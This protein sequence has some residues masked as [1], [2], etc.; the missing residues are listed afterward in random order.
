ME[1]YKKSGDIITEEEFDKACDELTDAIGKT[2]DGRDASVVCAACLS[3]A[4]SSA[5][6]IGSLD[7]MQ[8]LVMSL[9]YM[10]QE[11][12]KKIDE[13]TGASSALH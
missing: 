1:K 2:A 11:I 3:I 7:S 5:Q 6:Q 8:T 4:T 13:V 12:E 10:A 9:R